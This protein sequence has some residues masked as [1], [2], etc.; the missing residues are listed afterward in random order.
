LTGNHFWACNPVINREIRNV[1]ISFFILLYFSL[2]IN[3]ILA[4]N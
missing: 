1:E 4:E 2:N 3:L